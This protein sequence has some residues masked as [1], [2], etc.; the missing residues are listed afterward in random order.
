MNSN[1]S[2]NE[3]RMKKLWTLFPFIWLLFVWICIYFNR[4]WMHN[5]NGRWNRENDMTSLQQTNS[6]AKKTTDENRTKC[7]ELSLPFGWHTFG[8][9]FA[10]V[11]RQP[12]STARGINING[13]INRRTL[14]RAHRRNISR[15]F[16]SRFACL[17][18]FFS[19]VPQKS[20]NHLYLFEFRE[21]NSAW[22]SLWP[23]DGRVTLWVGIECKLNAAKFIR[24]H[25][26]WRRR[27]LK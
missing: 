6:N 4:M 17:S 12:A 22:N 8:V 18:S 15:T 20:D 10:S 26:D 21:W 24:S 9:F 13:H 7:A 2:D 1:N 3:N 16:D 5:K 23:I 11:P 27:F 25:L 14:N 19:F